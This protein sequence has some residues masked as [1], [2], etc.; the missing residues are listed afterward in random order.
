MIKWNKDI[1]KNDSS[2]IYV[3]WYDIKGTIQGNGGVVFNHDYPTAQVDLKARGDS[4]YHGHPKCCWRVSVEW[5]LRPS[6]LFSRPESHR[7]GGPAVYNFQASRS[8]LLAIMGLENPEDMDSGWTQPRILSW[9]ESGKFLYSLRDQFE[10]RQFTI[11]DL[12]DWLTKYKDLD[13]GL[14]LGRA[15]G[16]VDIDKRI[17]LLNWL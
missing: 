13:R 10:L 16:I 17:G 4:Q 12:L 6:G 15:M 5:K 14:R 2:E 8:D 3:T 7:I 1:H 9:Y 11:D